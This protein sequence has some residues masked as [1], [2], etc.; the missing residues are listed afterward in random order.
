MLTSVCIHKDND[1]VLKKLE[2]RI[3]SLIM[4]E[5]NARVRR[6][7]LNEISVPVKSPNRDIFDQ[8]ASTC[9]VQIRD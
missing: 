7:G 9:L 6:H 5:S 1:A 2:S 3:S 8:V 4:A